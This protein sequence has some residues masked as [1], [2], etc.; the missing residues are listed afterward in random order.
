MQGENCLKQ[1]LLLAAKQV[2]AD[3]VFGLLLPGVPIWEL[4]AVLANRCYQP[5]HP[6]A[7]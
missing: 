2:Q 4:G 7:S 6:T 3:G 5:P 1:W